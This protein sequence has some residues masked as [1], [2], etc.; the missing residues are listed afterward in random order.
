MDQ[1]ETLICDDAVD[2]YAERREQRDLELLGE[3]RLDST[4][5]DVSRQGKPLSEEEFLDESGD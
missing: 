2:L 1:Y 4:F 3:G 5:I